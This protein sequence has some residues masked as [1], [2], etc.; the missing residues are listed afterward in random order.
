M[1]VRRFRTVEAMERP[2][3]RNPGDPALYRVMQR[4]WEFGRRT[5]IRRFPPGVHRH[6]S[7]EALNEATARW[8]EANFRARRPPRE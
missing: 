1:P 7:I 4:L 3:W 8:S 5:A 2:T 6:R